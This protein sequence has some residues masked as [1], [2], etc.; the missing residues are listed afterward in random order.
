MILCMSCRRVYNSKYKRIG[1]Q[2]LHEVAEI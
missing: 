1:Q 2:I